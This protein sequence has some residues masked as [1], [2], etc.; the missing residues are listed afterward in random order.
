[1][2]ANEDD[3]KESWPQKTEG[4]RRGEAVKIVLAGMKY[5]D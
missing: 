1:M 3:T 5:A 4:K 2:G